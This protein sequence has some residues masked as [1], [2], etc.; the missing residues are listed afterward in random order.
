MPELRELLERSGFGGVR[1]Y[2]QSGNVVLRSARQP[3]TL[4]R[5]CERLLARELGVEVAVVAR[6]DAELAAVVRRNPLKE[7]ADDPK[8]HQ[9]TFLASRLPAATVRKL[10]A[11]VAPPEELVIAGREVYA[12]HPN[13]VARSRLWNTLAGKNLGVTATS[14]NWTTVEALHELAT[15]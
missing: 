15:A 11:A 13:G 3:E 8:R 5:E 6:T 2:L 10:E 7:V 9:V 1:T 14:R 12:W 4:A